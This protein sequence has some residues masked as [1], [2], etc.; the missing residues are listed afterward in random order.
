MAEEKTESRSVQ[1]PIIDSD[2]EVENHE[3]CDTVP[4][5]QK[6]RGVD[7]TCSSGVPNRLGLDWVWARVYNR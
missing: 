7:V 6:G 5:K 3:G 4:T 2:R 1:V